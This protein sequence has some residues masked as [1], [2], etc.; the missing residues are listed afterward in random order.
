VIVE[1]QRSTVARPEVASG[2]ARGGAPRAT[3]AAGSVPSVGLPMPP[4]L[5]S[6][7]GFRLSRVT[8]TLRA[9]WARQ[10]EE[11][12]LTPPQAAVVRGVAERPGGSLR[13]LARTL[14]AETMRTKRCIDELE[15]RGLVESA[16]GGGD[17]RPRA[18]ELTAA[19]REL[20]ARIDALV[21]LQ[22]R[23]LDEVLG[24]GRRAGLDAAITALEADLDLPPADRAPE[25]P[26]T[27][28]PVATT[29]GPDAARPRRPRPPISTKEPR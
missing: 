11:L 10:L 22:E 21:R 4:L 9:G 5:E 23:H 28:G 18:P 26:R 2:R 3:R 25:S 17:R 19:G 15:R 27:S 8:R 7:L 20:A 12:D 29:S 14:G 13:A 6:G 24:A 1:G 16:H